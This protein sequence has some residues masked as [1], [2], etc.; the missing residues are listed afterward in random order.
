MKYI[1]KRKSKAS[2]VDSNTNTTTLCGAIN[3]SEHAGLNSTGATRF[4]K[5]S[6]IAANNAV[7]SSGDVDLSSPLQV[8]KVSK[9]AQVVYWLSLR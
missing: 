7:V 8:E 6:E 9:P 3:A 2:I 4:I 5:G 1:E